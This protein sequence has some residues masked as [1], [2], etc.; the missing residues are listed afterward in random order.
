MSDIRESFLALSSGKRG[1]KTGQLVLLD[2]KIFSG[3]L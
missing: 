3:K 1:E 2:E